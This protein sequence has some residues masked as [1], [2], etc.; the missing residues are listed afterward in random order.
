[1]RISEF[2]VIKTNLIGFSINTEKQL[3]AKLTAGDFS[4]LYGDFVFI[5][6]GTSQNRGICIILSSAVN[7]NP[8]FYTIDAGVLLHGKNIFDVFSL[9]KTQEWNWN[10]DS[11]YCVSNIDHCIGGQSLHADI[12]LM[13]AG[14]ML[15]YFIGDE[16]ES[17]YPVVQSYEFNRNDFDDVFPAYQNML[18]DYFDEGKN[19][20]LSLSAGFDSRLLLASLLSKGIKPLTFTM[21]HDEA[22]DVKMAK[23]IA[24]DIGLNHQVISLSAEDYL[25]E[26]TARE[27]IRA[28]SG[29][30]TFAHWHTHIYIK[31]SGIPS[32]YV[33]LAGANGEIARS[34]FID[35]GI[36][37][38]LLQH[39]DMG[40]FRTFFKLKLQYG[41]HH[42]LDS[43]KDKVNQNVVLDA[44]V[45][46]SKAEAGN[47][48][49]KLDWFY[50]FERVRNFIAN[51]MALYNLHV[52]TISP[53]LD[54]RFLR[55]AFSL[56]RKYKLNS[57]FHKM[58]IEQLCPELMNY[59]NAEN[60]QN[61]KNTSTDFYWLKRQQ[62]HAYNLPN[63]VLELPVARSVIMESPLL[64]DW[65]DKAGREK[66]YA[67]KNYRMLTFL[68]MHHHT[69]LA[70]A[71]IQHNKQAAMKFK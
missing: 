40:L 60:T 29:T 53:F 22:T 16:K 5:A 47:T 26:N 3:L 64:E 66:L 33:H 36:F 27:I 24:R 41:N 10:Y 56:K 35:K 52:P 68:F 71:E 43:I 30:K 37:S 25:Q 17:L 15:V 59:P 42:V 23:K 32:G 7:A 63:E 1:M 62:V 50:S 65:I 9:M 55:L 48:A 20:A 38:K 18:N 44:I 28:T 54:E 69:L 19:I 57:C 2:S 58:A 14:T 21:G 51:G 11:L 13:P 45:N 6:E 49:D 8:Y 39:T 70:I 12:H 67:D 46:S 4:D 61:I 34:Y 31:K